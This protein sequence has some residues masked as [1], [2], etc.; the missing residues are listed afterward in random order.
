MKFFTSLFLITSGMFSCQSSSSELT[1]NE[2]EKIINEIEKI[3]RVNFEEAN[4]NDLQP[5]RSFIDNY[6]D[7][8]TAA[9]NGSYHESWEKGKDLKRI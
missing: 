2:Q 1:L 6:S 8:T 7:E 9:Y 3:A 4:I 5:R